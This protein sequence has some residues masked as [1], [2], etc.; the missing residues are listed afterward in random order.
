MVQGLA[1]AVPPPADARLLVAVSGGP[2]STALLLWLHESGRDVAAA[3][4]DHALRDGSDADAEHVGALCERLG[5]PL[6]RERR[7]VAL[8]PGSLQAAARAL[9][10]DFLARALSTTGRDLVCL[11]HTADDVVE[12]V[13]LHLLRGSGL[14]GMRGMPA[15]R[16]PFRRPFVH[17]WR[18]DVEA[19]LADRG[20][21]PLR[22]PSNA[23]AARYARSRARHFLLPALERDRP[24]LTRRLRGAA[25]AAARLQEGLES[26]AGRVV[27]G[28]APRAELRAA[29]RPLRLEV[30]RQLYGRLPGLD[31]RHL[32]AMDRLA[33]EGPTGAGLDLPGGLRFRVEPDRV[34]VGMTTPPAAPAPRLAVRPC[35]G[36]TDP[37]A[38]HLE[39]GLDLTVGYRRPGL[40]MRPQGAPGSRKLQDVLTDAKVPR[41]L[42]DGLPLVFANGRLAWVPGIA[43]DED[44]ALSP[45]SSGWHVSLQPDPPT[46]PAPSRRTEGTR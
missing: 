22:D 12:G 21:E 25:D 20:V 13:V 34:S 41:H 46:L 15:R 33:L 11:G 38:A 39:A 6:V 14:A 29:S 17:V 3:H 42:R 43:V 32:E 28:G 19:F 45:G 7:A 24:G 8:A 5:V 37:R 2:D 36:C 16:G 31:R 18:A 4:Y 10:Y 27:A 44:A 9:R 35:S 23:D 26:Q 1:G 30:Y 40:R